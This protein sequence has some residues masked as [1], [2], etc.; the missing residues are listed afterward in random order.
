MTLPA[1]PSALRAS[2]TAVARYA[3]TGA[4]AICGGHFSNSF[5]TY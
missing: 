4:C 5:A 1:P 2:D 3:S